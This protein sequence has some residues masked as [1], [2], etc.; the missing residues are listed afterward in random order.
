MPTMGR[1]VEAHAMSLSGKTLLISA[2]ALAGLIGL[3]YGAA[4]SIFH[5]VNDELVVS[6]VVVSVVVAGGGFFLV[7]LLLMHRLVLTRLKRLVAPIGGISASGDD[8]R[9]LQIDGRDRI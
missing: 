7:T 6:Y 8:C 4:A 2:L 9:R 5:S 3:L 1:C